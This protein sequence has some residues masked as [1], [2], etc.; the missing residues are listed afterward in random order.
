MNKND[1]HKNKWDTSIPLCAWLKTAD[2]ADRSA[3][4]GVVQALKAG[5]RIQVKLLTGKTLRGVLDHVTSESVFVESDGK[6]SEVTK[7]E[8]RRLYLK[9]KGSWQKSTL[10]GAGA[11]AAAGGAIGA[12]TMEKE[13]GYG[14]AVAGTVVLFAAIGAGIGYALRS[15]KSILVYEVPSQK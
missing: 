8:V 4:R 5:E 10:I 14:A 7:K 2:L 11:G 9:K 3:L 15:G 12:T 6:L 13:T 1:F